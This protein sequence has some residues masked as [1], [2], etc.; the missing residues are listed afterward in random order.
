MPQIGQTIAHY[1]ITDSIGQGGMG[2]VFLAEDTSLERKVAM[3]FLPR[4][5]QY[6]ELAQQRFLREA[7]SRGSRK[8]D[9]DSS[10]YGAR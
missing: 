6:D 2:E 8:C 1:K 5:M 4:D 7:K 10:P 9:A 3:K